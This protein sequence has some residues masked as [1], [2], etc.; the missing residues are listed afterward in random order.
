MMRGPL[1]PQ[2]RA[3]VWAQVSGRLGAIERGLTLVFEGIDCSAGQFG[4]VEG[5]A[6]DAMG[7]PVL[8][9]AAVDGDGLLA[10]R[11]HAASEF[12]ARIG[13]ALSDAVP[14][15]EFVAGAPGRVLVVGTEDGE[16]ALDLVRR[17]PLPALEVC[18]LDSFRLAGAERFVV[19]WL[20]RAE[21]ETVRPDPRP[22]ATRPRFDVPAG[23]RSEWDELQQ[24]CGRI[25]DSVRWDGD[26]YSRR[27]L[28]RGKLLGRVEIDAGALWGVDV[29]GKRHPL[30]APRERRHF[31][32]LLLRRFAHLSGVTF[33]AAPAGPGAPADASPAP[34][35]QE[36]LLASL[37][38]TRLSAEEYSALGNPSPAGSEA[39]PGAESDAAAGTGPAS[40]AAADAIAR[41]AAGERP[42]WTPEPRPGGLRRTD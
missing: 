30:Q 7:G 36:G 28:S 21:G 16:A 33:A 25:D 3:S 29:L 10:A 1:L 37:S 15:A 42:S 12:L 32:D 40:G 34:A 17:L 13:D 11:V 6:R 38:S 39:G 24:L 41:I 18:L 14:E 5:L 22:S 27:I 8:V 4:A 19:R 9:L 2:L 31:V 23:C 20:A 35:A 26:R